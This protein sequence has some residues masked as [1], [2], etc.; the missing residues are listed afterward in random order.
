M[1]QAEDQFEK[2]VVVVG[3]GLIGGSIAAA[4]RRRF[5][6]CRVTAIGRSEARL[7]KAKQRGLITGFATQVSPELLSDPAIVVVCLPVDMISDSVCEIAACCTAETVITDAGSVKESICLAVEKDS[8]AAAR[9]VGAHPIAGGENGGFEFSDADL[10]VDRTCVITP[11]DDGENNRRVAGFWK[12]IG[13]NVSEMKPAEHD[14][15]LALTSHLPHIVA[16]ATAS[17]V[18]R[19]NLPLCGSG[20]RDATRIA[21]GN[22]QL[23]RAILSENRAAVLGALEEVQTLLSAYRAAL[24][25]S[26][27][28]ALQKL[29]SDAADV[30]TELG[31]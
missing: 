20:F 29:L 24:E 16:A 14:R 15:V 30:R 27:D 17:A 28:G 6:D 31:Q 2:H 21:A 11:S 23:W 12:A 5:S 22:A 25:T 3:L 10:F 9:F 8:P 13:C 4:V 1:S 26:D 19:E 18:G 7:E